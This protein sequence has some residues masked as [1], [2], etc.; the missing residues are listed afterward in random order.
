[1]RF[2]HPDLAALLQENVTVVTPTPFLAG[3]ILRQYADYQS[4]QGVSTWVRPDV[5]SL[6]AWLRRSWKDAR[7]RACGSVPALLS[8]AQEIQVWQAIIEKSITSSEKP[9]LD[10]PATARAARNAAALIAE[11][12]LPLHDS[13]WEGHEDAQAFRHWFTQ[14]KK[15]CAREHWIC[16]SDLWSH[17][18]GWLEKHESSKSLIFAGFPEKS[19]A[20]N[21]LAATLEEQ[22]WTIRELHAKPTPGAIEYQAFQNWE[23]ELDTAARWARQTLEMNP[24]AHIGVL[25][26]KLTE[27]AALVERIFERILHPAHALAGICGDLPSERRSFSLG[28]RRSLLY[29]PVVANALLFL[30]LAKPQISSA[31][32]SAFLRSPFLGGAFAEADARARADRELHRLGELEYSRRQIQHSASNCFSLQRLLMRAEKVCSRMSPKMEAGAWAEWF[33]DLLAALAWPGTGLSASQEESIEQW[34]DLLS[35]FASLNLVTESMSL[36]RALALFRQLAEK[37]TG[38]A[39]DPAAPIQILDASEAAS[40]Q[41]DHVWIAGLT[42]ESWPPLPSLSPFLPVSLLHRFHVPA[43]HPE[44]HLQQSRRLTAQL[45]QSAPHVTVSYAKTIGDQ[46]LVPSAL[47]PGLRHPVQSPGYW[48]GHTIYEAICSESLAFEEFADSTGPPVAPDTLVRGG[49]RVLTAQSAC[50]F[51]AFAQ[52]RLRA[53]SVDDA[54][55]GYDAA[56]KGSFVHAAFAE[57]WAE[58]RTS[59]RL[60]AISLD[61]LRSIVQRAAGNAIRK[62]QADSPLYAHLRR[63]EQKRLEQVILDWL[64]KEKERLAE[65]EVVSLEEKKVC[66]LGELQ[67]EV[68]LDRV[69][70]LE[71]GELVVIDYKTGKVSLKDL[72]EQRPKSPQLLLYAETLKDQVGGLFFA[73]VRPRELKFLGSSRTSFLEKDSPLGD[74]WEL[75]LN[76]WH[77]VLEELSHQ[78]LSG[79]AAVDPK[80]KKNTCT[81]CPLD[82]LCR[83]NE[84]NVALTDSEVS[85]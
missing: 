81:Y 71:S 11:W 70:C 43:A 40:T 77:H 85:D 55:F 24:R 58:L 57:I 61:E 4:G 32:A 42:E 75:R 73:N 16:D 79:E 8:L 14:M 27:N 34:K 5:L 62:A 84:K 9:L 46:P 29:C 3:V 49:S 20:R 59:R 19:S 60:K 7:Y 37:Q 25:V 44:I 18:P 50:P 33:S 41:F 38:S 72:Y 48:N 22:G 52:I 36:D 53:S 67:V 13:S 30:E 31:T 68:R 17:I 21:H 23:E 6:Q 54:V 39:E 28:V 56:D 26:P 63:I 35:S 10:L 76:E 12:Q 1:M 51:Q 2:S 74:D 64:E 65:F 66:H 47:V 78:F 15:Q 82:P 83:I 45:L 69:D 80:S